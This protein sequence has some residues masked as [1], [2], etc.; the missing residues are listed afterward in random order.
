MGIL[1]DLP[2]TQRF[3]RNHNEKWDSSN[4]V[5]QKIELSSDLEG[6]G[7]QAAW[8][9]VMAKGDF[10]LLVGMEERGWVCTDLDEWSYDHMI[11]FI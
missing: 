3:R 1:W 8:K 10:P 4:T 11:L 7:S 9:K 6:H 2:R 5:V